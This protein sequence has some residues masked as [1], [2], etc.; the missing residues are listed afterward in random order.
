VLDIPGAADVGLERRRRGNHAS[1]SIQTIGQRMHKR[2]DVFARDRRTLHRQRAAPGTAD[3]LSKLT[4]R[5]EQAQQPAFV[6]FVRDH[7]ALLCDHARWMRPAL[8]A[9]KLHE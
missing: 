8:L 6:A 5:A 9:V 1:I 7:H 2:F 3:L 4:T